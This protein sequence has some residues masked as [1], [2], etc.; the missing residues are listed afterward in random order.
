MPVWPSRARPAI[1]G[2][3]VTGGKS[4]SGAAD[5]RVPA[6]GAG[7]DVADAGEDPLWQQAAHIDL[8]NLQRGKWKLP[9]QPVRPQP[10]PHDGKHAHHIGGSEE[11]RAEGAKRGKVDTLGHAA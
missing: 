7:A 1:A 11:G 6:G 9:A 10:V 4:V 2:K 3:I 5:F 8:L